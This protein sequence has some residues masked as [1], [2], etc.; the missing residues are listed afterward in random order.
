METQKLTQQ[1]I[2]NKFKRTQTWVSERL[3]LVTRLSPK[4]QEK[5]ITRAIKSLRY[6]STYK[7]RCNDVK[8]HYQLQ[9]RKKQKRKLFL[10]K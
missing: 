7:S 4:V 2:A 3:S 1:Q 6:K 9:G 5:V 8:K 10:E